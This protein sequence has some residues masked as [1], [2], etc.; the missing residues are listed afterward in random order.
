MQQQKWQQLA[1]GGALAEIIALTTL[2]PFYQI[3]KLWKPERQRVR[4][5]ELVP[6]DM[7]RNPQNL[8]IPVFETVGNIAFFIPLGLM[9]VILGVH[10]LTS[11]RLVAAVSGIGLLLSLSLEIAQYIFIVG[12][13]D[14]DD[15]WCNTLGATIGALLA[16][17]GG[18]RTYKFW[19]TIVLLSFPVFIA[20]VI[21]GPRLATQ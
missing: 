14:I 19:T 4:V 17:A 12:R 9:L 1:L 6:F 7:L 16:I 3:G 5:L 2:K 8:F 21:L 13:S 15:L 10:N 18:E 20:L 11:W